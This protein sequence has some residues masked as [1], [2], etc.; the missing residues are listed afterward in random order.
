MR[1]VAPW[2]NLFF[3]YKSN[4]RNLNSFFFKLS[5]PYSKKPCL[6]FFSY[7]H[8][9]VYINIAPLL[10]FA[11]KDKCSLVKY[12]MENEPM[13]GNCPFALLK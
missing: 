1:E 10:H 5:L 3:N 9:H 6:A 13:W 4:Y 8:S 2:V 11:S 7:A 12:K